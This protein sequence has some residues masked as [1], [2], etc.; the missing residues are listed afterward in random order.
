[1][2]SGLSFFT[3][4]W[5]L[6]ELKINT[7]ENNMN[8]ED[9]AKKEKKDTTENKKTKNKRPE[10]NTGQKFDHETIQI[11]LDDRISTGG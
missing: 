4:A 1:M 6:H 11:L 5:R 8:K 9:G 3:T 2:A 10:Q 7:V